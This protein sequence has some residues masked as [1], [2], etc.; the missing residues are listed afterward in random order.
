MQGPGSPLKVNGDVRYANIAPLKCF[1]PSAYSMPRRVWRAY[2]L[3]HRIPSHLSSVVVFTSS[4]SETRITVV[5]HSGVPMRPDFSEDLSWRAWNLLHILI[6]SRK[7][8]G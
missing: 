6:A 3:G 1:G 2:Q 4:G 7:I 5:T 8:K